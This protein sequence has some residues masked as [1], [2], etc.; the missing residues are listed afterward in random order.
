MKPTKDEWMEIK[1]VAISGDGV[2]TLFIDGYTVHIT[3]HR[4][5]DLQLKLFIYINGEMK[6]AWLNPENAEYKEIQNRFLRLRKK[7]YCP[8]TYKNVWT[9]RQARCNLYWQ[10]G[11]KRRL[12]MQCESFIHNYYPECIYILIP[13]AMGVNVFRTA[14]KHGI[15]LRRNPDIVYKIA[16]IGSGR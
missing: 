8:T 9:E 15:I 6:G 5:S 3:A 2:V 1:R 7:C 16:L 13:E 12:R 4:V 10:R 14:Y 11:V